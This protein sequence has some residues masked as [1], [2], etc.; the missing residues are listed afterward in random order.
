[1]MR[2]LAFLLA[3]GA[4]HAHAYGAAELF[5][6]LAQAKPARTAFHETR[7]LALLDKPVESSGELSFTPPAR[8]EKKTLA[9]KPESV[10]VDGDVLTLERGGRKRTMRLSEQPAIAVLIESLRATLAGDLPALER[11]FAVAVSGSRSDW[12]MTLTPRGA[13]LPIVRVAFAGKDNRIQWIEVL[14]TGGDRS[15]TTIGDEVR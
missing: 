6:A 1:M 15:V 8:L 10:V 4:G 7:H 3:L 2:A 11:H 12:S 14:E 5:A 13:T 9:P